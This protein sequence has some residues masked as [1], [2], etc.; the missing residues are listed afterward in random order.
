MAKIQR[1]AA[2][3]AAMRGAELLRLRPGGELLA[4][5]PDGVG[6][7]ER[8]IV[9]LRPTEQVKLDEPA[10]SSSRVSRESQ[11]RSNAC[12]SPLITLNRF[13]AAS[14]MTN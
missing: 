7:V 12:S 10:I 11:S 9:A 5:G 4:A 14:I 1:S 6:R 3:G 13:I 8:M 2:A